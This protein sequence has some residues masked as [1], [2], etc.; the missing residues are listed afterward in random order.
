MLGVREGSHTVVDRI[1]VDGKTCDFAGGCGDLSG[2]IR[3][4]RCQLAG[5]RYFELSTAESDPIR[6]EVN[7]V[8]VPRE[9]AQPIVDGRIT[10][11]ES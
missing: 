9:C 10:D 4:G 6:P 7:P 11:R 8:G 2:N 3:V 5:R 1:P